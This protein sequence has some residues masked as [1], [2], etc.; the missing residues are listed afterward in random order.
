MS[1]MYD[2]HR[3]DVSASFAAVAKY[4]GVEIRLCPPRRGQ[5][6]G[7]VEKNNDYAAQRWWRTLSDEV[8]PSRAQASLD[9]WCARTGNL[10]VR[11]K[12]SRR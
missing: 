12:D 10:R 9:A 4:Y 5:R 2:R 6:K 11:W 1:T 8:T 7:S 3:D